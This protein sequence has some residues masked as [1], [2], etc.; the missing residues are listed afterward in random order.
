MTCPHL[1]Y[2]DS[3]GEREFETARAFCTVTDTF[4]QPV[5]ADICNERY[6]LDPEADCKY[7][8]E[9]AGLDWDE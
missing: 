2:R 8:R 3:H 9:H 1:E 4:V 5:R 7:F 6:D